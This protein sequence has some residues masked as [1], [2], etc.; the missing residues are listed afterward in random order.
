MPGGDLLFEVRQAQPSLFGHARRRDPRGQ[1]HR[2]GP[3]LWGNRTVGGRPRLAP[4]GTLARE[5]VQLVLRVQ[6]GLN[7]HIHLHVIGL[8]AYG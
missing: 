7:L 6:R 2:V 3:A 1:R 8:L 4:V 5:L